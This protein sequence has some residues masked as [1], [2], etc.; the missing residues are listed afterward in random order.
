[1]IPRSTATVGARLKYNGYAT[2]WFAKNYNTPDWESSVAGPFDRWP[3][4]FGID[5][6]GLGSDT[7]SPVTNTYKAPFPFTGTIE[8]VDIVLGTVQLD[9]GRRGKVA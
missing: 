6:F 4:G 9:S 5:T 7:G 2:S 1:M 8:R 3:A